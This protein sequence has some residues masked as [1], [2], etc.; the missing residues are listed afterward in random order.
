MEL[1]GVKKLDK[2]V[3]KLVRAY[4]CDDIRCHFNTEFAVVD[5]NVYYSLFQSEET[6]RIWAA[7]LKDTYGRRYKKDFS[8]FVLSFLHEIGHYFTID[9]YDDA[10]D[11]KANLVIDFDAD[12]DEEIVEKNRAYWELPVEKAAT[13]WAIDF[14]NSHREEMKIF[15]KDLIAIIGDF[16]RKNLTK[17]YE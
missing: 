6:D 4:I 8:T 3:T 2:S 17:D 16:Y 11:E 9:D 1:K 12:S 15:Y 5:E 13:D 7:W 10:F 14:Y